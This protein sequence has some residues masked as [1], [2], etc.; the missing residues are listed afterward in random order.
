VLAGRSRKAILVGEAKWAK[1]VNGEGVRRSLQAKAR[2]LPAT[3]ETLVYAACGREKVSPAAGLRYT[4]GTTGA[5][6]GCVL[7]HEYWLLMGQRSWEL[8]GLGESDCALTAQPFHYMD[9]Q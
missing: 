2:Q 8:T 7:T 3:A 5:P 1:A 6:K 4:S 9:P